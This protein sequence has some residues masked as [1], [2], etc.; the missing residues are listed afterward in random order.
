MAPARLG[1]ERLPFSYAYRRF[2]D[3]GIVVTGSSDGPIEDLNPWA[4]IWAAVNRSDR[5][6]L[7]E[8]LR[9]YTINP[10]IALGRG[11]EFGKIL[12]GFRADFTILRGNP[13]VIPAKELK[14]T[15]HRSTFLEGKLVWGER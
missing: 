4:G 8:A 10:W 11:N 9:M 13:F 7:D 5:L 2:V 1:Q 12:P 14:N 15:R 6:T 3:E